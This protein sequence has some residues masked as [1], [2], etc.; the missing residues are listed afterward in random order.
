MAGT[1]NAGS[2]EPL[3]PNGLW[4]DRGGTSPEVALGASPILGRQSDLLDIIS[5]IGDADGAAR[6]ESSPKRL[7]HQPDQVPGSIQQVIDC[8][9]AGRQPGIT[10][11][12][13]GNILDGG[14]EPVETVV[15]PAKILLAHDALPNRDLEILRPPACFVGPLPV[16]GAA[17]PATTTRA[18][19]ESQRSMTPAAPGTIR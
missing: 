15:Q 12:V 5:L 7:D 6:W 16:R 8:L 2:I 4:D 11:Q 17:E 9:T 13:L 18:V 19:P 14:L 10:G 3:S 1:T